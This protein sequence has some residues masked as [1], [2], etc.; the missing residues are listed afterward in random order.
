MEKLKDIFFWDNKVLTTKQVAKTY[1]AKIS[2]VLSVL[3]DAEKAEEKT[4][5]YYI[6]G[7]EWEWYVKSNGLKESTK[8]KKTQYL[9]TNRGALLIARKINTEDAW[10]GYDRLISGYFK[11]SS[12]RAYNL[13]APRKTTWYERHEQD[14]YD[15][16][17][18]ENMTAKEV[19]KSI[20]I[21]LSGEFNIDE[22]K[23]IYKQETGKN[24]KYTLDLLNLFPEMAE[25][26]NKILYTMSSDLRN[27]IF[28]TTTGD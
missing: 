28:Q 15:L 1:N 5:Y 22:A 25:S 21:S 9:W 18:F 16:C 20:V 14:I 24:V 17:N 12:Q 13:K 23:K 7:D 10:N 6:K 27:Y 19:V 8:R 2:E 4:H 3:E 11:E 26:A